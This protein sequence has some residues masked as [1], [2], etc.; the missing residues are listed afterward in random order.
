MTLQITV[1]DGS[2]WVGDDTRS[3]EIT[4]QRLRGPTED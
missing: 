1:Q 2:V 4:L 3:V